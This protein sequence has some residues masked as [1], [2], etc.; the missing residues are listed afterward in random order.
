[1]QL[2]LDKDGKLSF[3]E[4]KPLANE[5]LQHERKLGKLRNKP[6]D[7]YETHW[8]KAVVIAIRP[9]DTYDLFLPSSVNVRFLKP[10][11][12]RQP[13]ARLRPLQEQNGSGQ[14]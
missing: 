7:T 3:D 9:D 4:F 12:L 8:V 14:Q 2:D 10:M 6:P 5:L 11:L 13:Q 1:M